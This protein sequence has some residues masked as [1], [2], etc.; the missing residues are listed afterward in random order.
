M[1]MP[2]E[3]QT[4]ARKEARKPEEEPA[5]PV[6]PASSKGTSSGGSGGPVDD[7]L[8]GRALRLFWDKVFSP[9]K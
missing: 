6:P 3:K 7:G 9:F 8:G 2:E 4:Q 1:P 5:Q